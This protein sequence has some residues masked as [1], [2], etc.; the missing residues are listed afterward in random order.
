MGLDQLSTEVNPDHR[1]V[2]THV[3]VFPYVLCWDGIQSRV[4]TDVMVRVNRTT[5]PPRYDEPLRTK[6]NE[7]RLFFG[8]KH[9][10]RH[11]A[12]R[13]MEAAPGGVAAPI[14]RSTPDVFQALVNATY[15]PLRT[16]Y[17]QERGFT[18]TEFGTDIYTEGSRTKRTWRSTTGLSL[19][20]YGRA[21]SGRKPRKVAYSRNVRLKRGA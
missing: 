21:G 18:L 2:G 5:A 16:F 17:A 1:A 6:R 8:L 9:L 15:E 14:Q 4:E 10:Q 20:W 7:R 13:A 19:G 11:A 3:D 12:S